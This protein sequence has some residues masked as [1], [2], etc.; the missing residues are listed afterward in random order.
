MQ[1]YFRYRTNLYPVHA[2]DPDSNFCCIRVIEQS[3]NESHKKPQYND[4]FH[5]T[6]TTAMQWSYGTQHTLD[7]RNERIY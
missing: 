7:P 2:S 4:R 5:A 6:T 3:P 1:K